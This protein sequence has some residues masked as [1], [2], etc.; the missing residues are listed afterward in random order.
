MAHMRLE[1]QEQAQRAFAQGMLWMEQQP[2]DH[3]ELRC[4][5]DETRSILF[6]APETSDTAR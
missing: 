6:T 1:N 2:A 5:R 3:A 4:L